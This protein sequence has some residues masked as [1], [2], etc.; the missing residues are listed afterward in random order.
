MK[1]AYTSVS[2]FIIGT[3]ITRGIIADKHGQLIAKELSTLGYH[4]NRVTIVPDD[5]SIAPLLRDAVNHTDIVILTG[6]LGPTSDDMTRQVVAELA[7]VPLVQDEQ[8]F[9]HLYERIGERIYG[10]NQRQVMFPL[11]F[12]VIEN[13]K[14][15]APGFSGELPVVDVEGNTRGVLCYAMPGPPVEMHE[16][17]YHRILPELAQ[18][19]G[20]KELGRDEFSCFLTPESRLEDISSECAADGIVWGT[21]VQEH[22]IS[23]YLNGGTAENR[24][25][26]ARRIGDRL[27]TG[28]LMEGDIEVFDLL[29][30]ALKERGLTMSCAES[31]TGGLI[32]KLM[33]DRDGSSA[34]F[35]GSVISYANSAKERLLGVPAVTLQEHGAVS[36]KTVKKMAESLL[37]VSGTDLVISVSGIAGPA[38]GTPD[39]PVG[40]VWLGFAAKGKPSAAV[41][42]NITSFGRASVRRR[43]AIAAILLGYFHLNGTDLLDIVGTWQYI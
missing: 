27:G 37:E 24:R 29:A 13:P 11:G 6:G 8:A 40:T 43:A 10:A 25:A 42:L 31:C 36:E 3:E 20:Q 1:T 41:Q 7:Q 14:G 33:T 21:R 34:W 4:V 26:M 35:W 2:V 38:G 15:T 9:A 28:L 12:R 17:F 30:E 23:L 39:K 32:S 18:L 5:G 22:R 19:S 16:M